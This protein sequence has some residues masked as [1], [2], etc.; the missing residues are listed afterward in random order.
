MRSGKNNQRGLLR[1]KFDSTSKHGCLISGWGNF[2]TKPVAST[3][4]LYC[5]PQQIKQ[6]CDRTL[7]GLFLLQ[8]EHKQ[9]C[10]N[11]F[12]IRVCICC[13]HIYIYIYIYI[14]L[15]LIS[16]CHTHF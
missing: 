7:K 3:Y 16:H 1:L 2:T 10:S 6:V 8:I 9:P 14:Y 11:T 15:G 4:I 13:I 5:N 12:F